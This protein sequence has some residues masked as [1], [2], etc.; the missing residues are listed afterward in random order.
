MSNTNRSDTQSCLLNSTFYKAGTLIPFGSRFGAG[1]VMYNYSTGMIVPQT[2]NGTIRLDAGQV[3]TVEE[4][5]SKAMRLCKL[6]EA[7]GQPRRNSDMPPGFFKSLTLGR[8]SNRRRSDSSVNNPGY[9]RKISNSRGSINMLKAAMES[10]D[11]GLEM[12]KS[13]VTNL[14]GKTTSGNFVSSTMPGSD[15]SLEQSSPAA[16]F[17]LRKKPKKVSAEPEP[18]HDQAFKEVAKSML[19]M[20]NSQAKMDDE[21]DLVAFLKGPGRERAKSTT[22][23]RPESLIIENKLPTSSNNDSNIDESLTSVATSDPGIE[24]RWATTTPRSQYPSS[25][26]SAHQSLQP[27]PNQVNTPTFNADATFSAETYGTNGDICSSSSAQDISRLSASIPYKGSIGGIQMIDAE[28]LTH[29][30]YMKSATSTGSNLYFRLSD[31]ILRAFK[32][33]DTSIT[34]KPIIELKLGNSFAM[35]L[36]STTD[37]GFEIT[38]SDGK[39]RCYPSSYANMI[40]WISTLNTASSNISVWHGPAQVPL[41]DYHMDL[42]GKEYHALLSVLR[43]ET[44]LTDQAAMDLGAEVMN[45]DLPHSPSRQRS[46]DDQG[47]AIIIYQPDPDGIQSPFHIVQATIEKLVERMTDIYGPDKAFISM[48]LHTYRH[49]VSTSAFLSMLKARLHVVIPQDEEAGDDLFSVNWKIVVKIRT[50]SVVYLWIKTIWSPDF[51][52]PEARESLEQF[53]AAIQGSFG[54]L[55]SDKVLES[56]HLN[57]FKLLAGHFRGVIRRREALYAA[58]SPPPSEI[59]PVLTT[60]KL[61]FI[62][63]EP[64]ELAK[65]LTLREQEYLNAIKPIQFLLRV[66]SNEKDPIIE[67]EVRPLND[68][69]NAFNT[70]SFWVATEVCTQPEIKNRAKVIENFI[71]LAKECRKLNNF[72]TLMAI[73]SG[74]NVVAVSRLKATWEL[75]DAKRVRQLNELETL[76]SP[77]N[78]FRMYRALVNDIE[79]EPNKNR[80]YYVPILSLFLKDFLFMNDG[81][82]KITESGCINVDKLRSMYTRA[83]E[84]VP[85]SNSRQS[86]GVGSPSTP[87]QQYCNNLRALKEPVLYKYS[88]LCEPKNNTGDDLRLREKW[89]AQQKPHT[90]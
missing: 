3:Y 2:A 62:D 40:M 44:G 87:I 35:P 32:D 45:D 59:A 41:E 1:Y 25:C 68:A 17:S 20:T 4:A 23:N 88:C 65:H 21:L 64:A 47:K 16:F 13:K 58:Y 74:L 85:V 51:I 77:T 42:Y 19:V 83:T 46:F 8:S 31:N 60:S 12:D 80:R 56:Q 78:N 50:I 81:N 63:F 48:M 9:S 6:P 89:M 90:N 33:I 67:R 53:V 84:I 30:G 52:Y 15:M 57:E 36:R 75:T 29:E 22:S 39:L 43:D 28:P 5:N 26:N 66:W 82:P 34:S 61:G 38:H 71:K 18:F 72:N 11:E 70:V 7:I 10:K 86:S 27:T 79:E 55:D 37:F 73:V 49:I 69:V 76:I 24:N 54:P 14:A